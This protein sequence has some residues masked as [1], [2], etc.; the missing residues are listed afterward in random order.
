MQPRDEEV[1]AQLDRRLADTVDTTVD[2]GAVA[3]HQVVDD[4][5]EPV[6]GLAREERHQTERWQR[7]SV[8]SND[9]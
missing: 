3:R 1:R 6:G 9:I 2:H 5:I 8:S 7:R 4:I